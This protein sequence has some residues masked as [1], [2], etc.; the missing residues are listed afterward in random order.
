MGKTDAIRDVIARYLS[1]YENHDSAGCSAVYAPDAIVLSPWGP[2]LHGPD[3]IAAAHID[4]FEAGETNKTMKIRD[5]IVDGRT[6]IC[7]VTYAADVPAESGSPEKVF[8]ASLNTLQCQPD[9]SWKIRHTSLTELD[10]NTT[11]ERI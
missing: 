8:G 1:A 3:A 4:W 11:S 2:P 6:A 9:G 5:L 10:D 7:L